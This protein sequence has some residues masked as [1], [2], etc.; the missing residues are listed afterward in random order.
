[1]ARRR[2]FQ[3]Q[4]DA[5]RCEAM[6]TTTSPT[7]ILQIDRGAGLIGSAG[8]GTR[9]R[10]IGLPPF[11]YGSLWVPCFCVLATRAHSLSH[12]TVCK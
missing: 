4:C 6:T 12:K 5:M 11:D 10:L 7:M 1:M 3:V 9:S 2:R 8:L